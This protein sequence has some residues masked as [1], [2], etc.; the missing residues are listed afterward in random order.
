M[1]IGSGGARGPFTVGLGPGVIQT[2]SH[3]KIGF[4]RS[5]ISRHFENGPFGEPEVRTVR[6]STEELDVQ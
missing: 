2:S 6:I 3:F 1:G 4:L 5:Q